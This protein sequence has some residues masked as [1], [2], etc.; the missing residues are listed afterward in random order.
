M[1][2][3]VDNKSFPISGNPIVHVSDSIQDP[4]IPTKLIDY[5]ESFEITKR[6]LGSIIIPYVYFRSTIYSGE[7]IIILH[8]KYTIDLSDIYKY[9]RG[10][11]GLRRRILPLT[12]SGHKWEL[13]FSNTY[14]V[15]CVDDGDWTSKLT[16]KYEDYSFR[17]LD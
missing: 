11:R 9:Y 2:L 1:E 10:S 3:I 8:S 4:N 7:L 15:E 16:F 13:N 6:G 12:I 14:L 5:D 17:K